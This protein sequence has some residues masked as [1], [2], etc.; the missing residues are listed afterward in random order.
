MSEIIVKSAAEKDRQLG[1][2]RTVIQF[3][4]GGATASLTDVTD[5]PGLTIATLANTTFTISGFE[6]END[7]ALDTSR[8]AAIT[9]SVGTL[10]GLNAVEGSE[11]YV[12]S[13]VSSGTA[14]SRIIT[15]TLGGA[16]LDLDGADGF[17][18]AVIDCAIPIKAKDF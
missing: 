8:R 12:V 13:A 5:G 15:V 6:A 16:A 4:A 3:T 10:T 11:I 9:L 18:N 1:I 7:V 17:T 14:G 2:H